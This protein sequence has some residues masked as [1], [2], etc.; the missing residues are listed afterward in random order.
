M[1]QLWQWKWYWVEWWEWPWW[2]WEWQWQWWLD[3]QREWWEQQW[4]QWE[5]S[6]LLNYFSW[7]LID[8]SLHLNIIDRIDSKYTRH[9]ILRPQYHCCKQEDD[10]HNTLTPSKQST[11][12]VDLLTRIRSPNHS[13]FSSTLHSSPSHHNSVLANTPTEILFINP[14]INTLPTQMRIVISNELWANERYY[15]T[16]RIGS[17]PAILN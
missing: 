16:A 7:I 15:L 3:K 12:L 1:S 2:W 10:K 9:T 14:P 6:I 13:T 4:K 11:P 8:N 5:W 17:F